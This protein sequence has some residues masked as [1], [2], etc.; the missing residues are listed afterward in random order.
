MYP[1]MSF[2]VTSLLEISQT[3]NKRAEKWLLGASSSLGFDE[4]ISYLDTL[5][6]KIAE[7]LFPG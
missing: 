3:F 1:E 4:R 2:K 6:L 5:T 7:H